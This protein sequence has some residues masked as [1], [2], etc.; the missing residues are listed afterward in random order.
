MRCRPRDG[1]RDLA[2]GISD[3]DSDLNKGPSIY[4]YREE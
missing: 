3:Q 1:G 4:I 2:S